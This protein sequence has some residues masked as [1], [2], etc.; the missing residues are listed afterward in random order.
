MTRSVKA[1]YIYLLTPEM[2]CTCSTTICSR[3]AR[4]DRAPES[5]TLLSLVQRRRETPLR[6][7][8]LTPETTTTGLLTRW[9]LVQRGTHRTQFVIITSQSNRENMA[10]PMGSHG[11]GMTPHRARQVQKE[12]FENTAKLR[13]FY[14]I[15]F[16]KVPTQADPTHRHSTILLCKN[17][18]QW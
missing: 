6:A 18:P 8:T 13:R 17:N 10:T 3:N 15:E 2:P 16:E 7:T 5:P 12:H 1:L 11:D 14:N 9:G 4:H